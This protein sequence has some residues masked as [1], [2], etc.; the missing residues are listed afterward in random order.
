MKFLIESVW[1]IHTPMKLVD[2]GCG[3]GFLGSLMLPYLPKGS[4]YTG[5]DIDG[6]LLNEAKTAFESSGFSATWIQEDLYS[7]QP[8]Q[9]YDLAICQAFLRHTNDAFGLLGKMIQS[10]RSGGLIVCIEICREFESDGIYMDGLDYDL[11]CSR[12]GFRNLWKNEY[13][14]QGRDY[15]I[16]MR[17]PFMMEQAGLQNVSVRLNDKIEFVTPN[18]LD[19]QANTEDFIKSKG[20]DVPLTEAE[21]KSLSIHYLNHGMTPAE[22][23][24]SFQKRETVH[25]FVQAQKDQLCFLHTYGMLISFG[26]KA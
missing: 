18:Q 11:L 13:I 10:V 20:W 21:R 12:D 3:F 5:I 25:R 8:D 22:A 9:K 24:S 1:D 15:A 14:N 26:W 7:Y 4:S 2:F 16:G 23:E 6:K 19:Y 17:L